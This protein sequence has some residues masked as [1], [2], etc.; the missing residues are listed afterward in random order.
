MKAKTPPSLIADAA[1]IADAL[2]DAGRTFDTAEVAKQIQLLTSVDLTYLTIGQLAV[3]VEAERRV[4]RKVLAEIPGQPLPMPKDPDA[5]ITQ[6]IYELLELIP[7]PT[8]F[9]VRLGQVDSLLDVI[10]GLVAHIRATTN[11]VPA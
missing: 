2:A 3:T 7:D 4:V 1:A 8:A 9:Y 5:P 10:T 11:A 6:V